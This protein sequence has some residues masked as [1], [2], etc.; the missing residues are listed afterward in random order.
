MQKR[1]LGKS[2]LE[3]SALGEG[4]NSLVDTLPLGGAVLCFAGALPESAA[5][6]AE[7]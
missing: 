7:A 4:L 5:R 3:V 2:G 6:S 1:E